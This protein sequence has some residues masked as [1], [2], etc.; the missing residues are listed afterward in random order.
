MEQVL[1]WAL[2]ARPNLPAMWTLL[3]RE[4]GKALRWPCLAICE[5]LGKSLLL[6]ESRGTRAKNSDNDCA[7]Y[8][9]LSEM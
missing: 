8:G 3:A 1:W 7:K 5:I 6:C 2:L 4:L 9:L